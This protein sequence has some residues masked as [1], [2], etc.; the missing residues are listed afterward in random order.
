MHED[1]IVRTFS[2]NDAARQLKRART[3]ILARRCVLGICQI[4]RRNWTLDQ[5]ALF[6]RCNDKEIA[7]KLGRT[8]SSVENRRT[9]LK[10]HVPKPGWRFFTP[11]EDA[12]LC[13]VSE[14]E[15][16]KRIALS[17]GRGH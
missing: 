4:I 5:D 17:A 11:E 16:A 12:L 14:A 2:P 15:I 6:L 8:L 7:E 3:A 1:S 9:R 13:T 10:I